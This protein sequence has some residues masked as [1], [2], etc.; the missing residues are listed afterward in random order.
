MPG[1]SGHEALDGFDGLDAPTCANSGAVQ[2]GG[3]TRKLELALQRPALQ[4]RVDKS[5][6]KNVSRSRG[7]HG[8]NAKGWSIV[9][10]RAV[11]SEHT[12]FAQ[13]CGGE[14]AAKPALHGGQRFAQIVFAGKPAWNI[15]ASNQAI[16]IFQ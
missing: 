15:S 16:D 8:L 5:R 12:F 11:P 4:Q 6:M 1:A 3:G 2:R 7:V 10:L 13:S 14:P 9:E